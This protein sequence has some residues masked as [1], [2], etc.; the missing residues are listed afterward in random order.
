[1]GTVLDLFS[2]KQF[3][4]PKPREEITPR[5]LKRILALEKAGR[6]H[7]QRKR[8]GYGTYIPISGSEVGIFSRLNNPWNGKFTDLERELR[9]LRLPDETII[10]GEML[11]YN[12]KGRDDPHLFGRF[13]RTNREGSILLQRGYDPVHVALFDVL[14]WG[15]HDV[16]TLPY[17][18]R[19]GIVMEICA[20]G[21]DHVSVAEHVDLPYDAAQ[22]HGNR[23]AWEG[24]ILRDLDAGTEFR[25]DGVS[26]EPPRPDGCWKK[27]PFQES[28][29][30]A[31]RWIPSDSKKYKGLVRD[32]IL[33][34][35]DPRTGK[36]V[37]WG[38]VGNGLTEEQKRLFTDD[39]LYPF[40]VQVK[41]E[42]RTRNFRLQKAS[43]MRIRDDKTPEECRYPPLERAA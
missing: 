38:P 40:V 32:L 20:K 7:I 29:F 23:L 36:L 19:L 4:G 43:I 35:Y 25:L 2:R 11:A 34:Q 31:V 26:A 15:G 10:C 16:T 21:R 30:I 42:L 17:A 1:M 39:S 27:K 12:S 5:D 37:E 22:Q 3:V 24:L 18:E 8:D 9:G 13:A 6:L 28:D 33:A 41:F 14:K